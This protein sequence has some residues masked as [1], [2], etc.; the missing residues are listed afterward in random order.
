MRDIASFGAYA[1]PNS[2]LC[3]R[4]VGEPLGVRVAQKRKKEANLWS[5]VQ[6]GA[7]GGIF[8]YGEYIRPL[9]L[10]SELSDL[11]VGYANPIRARR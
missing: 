2:K 1:P 3:L 8:A 4:A 7:Y 5:C 9:R 11:R 6:K 10:E